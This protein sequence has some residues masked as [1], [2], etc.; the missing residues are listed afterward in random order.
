M[1][2]RSALFDVYGGHL[3]RRGG[4]ASV[5]ALVLLLAPL[6][7]AAPAVRTAVSRMVKQ[8]WLAPVKLPE[9][10][11]Y[12]ITPRAE[13]RLDEAAA[14]IYR[15]RPATWDGRWHIVVLEELPART[16]RDRITSSLRL[17]GY[18]ELGPATWIAPRPAA[19]L[20][21]LLA[22]EQVEARLFHGEHD[23]P[24]AELVATAWDLD[25]LAGDY[26]DFLD[27]WRDRL[28]QADAGNSG[29]AFATSQQ[30]LHSWRNFLFSDPG[31][32]ARLLPADW[33]GHAAA[34]LFDSHTA[35]LAPAAGQFVD[36]CLSPAT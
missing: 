32:P 8:D 28:A 17:L 12:A 9:G 35:R 36:D 1:R 22:A 18:G 26:A 11:G 10:P 24:D 4:E 34:E 3:R 23:G 2:A 33:P 30:L 7:I 29:V 21:E 19:E 14:R 25:S 6:G 20:R 13:R 5:A 15:T 31:L 16:A 27:Q